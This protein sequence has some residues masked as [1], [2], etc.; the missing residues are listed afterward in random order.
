MKAQIGFL[1]LVDSLLLS[2]DGSNYRSEKIEYSVTQE[3]VLSLDE[4]LNN[5]EFQ[6]KQ[7][8][9]EFKTD[10]LRRKLPFEKVVYGGE[11]ME[12]GYVLDNIAADYKVRFS[13]VDNLILV[14]E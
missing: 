1:F 4:V 14:D 11:D 2:C 12:F 3:T 10:A 9:F 13:V 6:D 5:I 7:Y 8:S